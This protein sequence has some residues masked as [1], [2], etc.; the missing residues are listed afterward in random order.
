MKSIVW[1]CC[2]LVTVVGYTGCSSSKYGPTPGCTGSKYEEAYEYVLVS[3]KVDSLFRKSVERGSIGNLK[4]SNRVVESSYMSWGG[5][6]ESKSELLN[7]F[8]E[9]G[10]SVS[11]DY[12]EVDTLMAIDEGRSVKK[13]VKKIESIGLDKEKGVTLFFSHP[14][15]NTI[16]GEIAYAEEGGSLKGVFSRT[17]TVQILYYFNDRGCIREAYP[18][19]MIYD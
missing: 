17:E 10:G 2:I 12:L 18:R 7:A 14:L 13:E 11:E 4:V 3:P 5:V 8:I 9:G 1:F 16:I 19:I 15:G 6:V